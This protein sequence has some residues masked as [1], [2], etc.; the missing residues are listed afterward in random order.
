MGIPTYFRFLIEKYNNIVLEKNKDS[1][2][3]FFLDFNSIL[4]KV[5][6][7]NEKNKLYEDV[8]LRNI[9][10]EL[11]TLCNQKLRPSK[12][13]YFSFDGPAPRAKMVQQRSRRYKSVQLQ[14]YFERENEWNPSNNICPGT[15]F[16]SRLKSI[17][18][19]TI[20]NG[21]FD[22]PNVI[23]SDSSVPG[24]G[25]HKILPLI[26]SLKTKDKDASVYIMSPDNDLISLGVLTG[27][28]NTY[29]VR[30]VD[31]TLATMLKL[32]SFD[33]QKVIFIDLDYLNKQFSLEQQTKLQMKVDEKNLLLDYNFLL[34]MIGNDF[35]VSLP[36]MKIKSGGLDKLIRI[37]NGILQNRKEYL[38]D[39]KS[40][41]V[42]ND[43]FIELI[44]HLSR[45]ENNE[46]KH[47][48]SFIEREKHT[49]NIPRHDSRMSQKQ[50]FENNVQ[51]LYL[52]DPH[53]PLYEMYERDFN[54]INFSE[55][56]HI[57]K[58]KYYEHFCNVRKDNYNN[59][60]NN[61]VLEY[62]KSLKFTLL[63]YNK[64]CPSWNWYYP[65]R[66]APLFSDLYTNLTKFGVDINK[67]VQ[68][69][70]GKPFTPFQQ[71][72]LILPPQSKNILPREFLK[73]FQKY[74]KYYPEE[75]RVDALQGM[76]YIYS[77]AILHEFDN[78]EQFM[79]DIKKA[80]Q[81]LSDL[82]KHRNKIVPLVYKFSK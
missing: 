36:Y 62:L 71:L 65:Y 8:F 54:V 5:L 56:N 42:N 25:E 20:Q 13:V 79:N 10:R 16:M 76:K 50:K 75:F 7:D 44:G 28:T 70:L 48:H 21:E 18:L 19:R 22:C 34:S 38:V 63:Y 24:E 47:F 29:L 30:Y 68:F 1:V 35:V 53:N 49:T 59:T 46:F 3:Y 39:P 60:R 67:N 11:K 58:F 69:T 66:I 55:P 12:M 15:E 41:N 26:R 77:E 80:E 72:M 82:E 64:G 81:E 57:W 33:K 2:D 32:N 61:I 14:T 9:I 4:Y 23:L 45:M 27:K 31:K 74:K 17:L 43:F 52:C 78:F 37:Y 73:V 6:Y 40:L 51:H